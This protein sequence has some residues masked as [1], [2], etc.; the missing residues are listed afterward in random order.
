MCSPATRGLPARSTS[1]AWARTRTSVP[2][3]G[4]RYEQGGGGGGGRQ[5]SKGCSG[6]ELARGGRGERNG[7]TALGIVCSVC[8]QMRGGAEEGAKGGQEGGGKKWEG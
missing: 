6:S 7:G 1:D 2:C 3:A 4:L 8:V 5:V